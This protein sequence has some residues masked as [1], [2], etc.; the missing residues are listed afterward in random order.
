MHFKNGLNII[1][2]KVLIMTL[3]KIL[4]RKSKIKM[5]QQVRQDVIEEEEHG[6]IL[7]ERFGCK[8]ICIKVEI[9][10]GEE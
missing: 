10:M 1:Q 7:I 5:V 4:K 8:I 2:N 3:K 6:S 9:Q